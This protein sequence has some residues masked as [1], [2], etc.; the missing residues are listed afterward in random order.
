M[1]RQGLMASITG[2]PW[3]ATPKLR[4]KKAMRASTS[5][6]PHGLLVYA[7]LLEAQML[8]TWRAKQGRSPGE[9]DAVKVILAIAFLLSPLGSTITCP[10]K[11][12]CSNTYYTDSAVLA[13]GVNAPK[14]GSALLTPLRLPPKG[15]SCRNLP[16]INHTVSNRLCV[17]VVPR[18]QALLA[19]R[20]DQVARLRSLRFQ[21]ELVMRIRRHY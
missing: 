4:N 15:L 12:F 18:R 16:D 3:G 8:D 11:G 10:R 21:V 6:L 5:M 7:V 19:V 1:N 9:T 2:A 14:H 13:I 17:L 20:I